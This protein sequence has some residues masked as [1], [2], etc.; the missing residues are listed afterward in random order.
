M[1]RSFVLNA[2]LILIP[3]AFLAQVPTQRSQFPQM[4]RVAL[5]DFVRGRTD[6][7]AS[8]PDSSLRE[9]LNRDERLIVIDRSMMQAALTGV[10]YAG[11]LN[12]TR[13]DARRLGSAIG[14]DFFIFGKTEALTRSEREHESHEE[15]YAGVLIVDGRTG[16]LAVFDFTSER[17]ATR[18]AAVNAVS[19]I[20]ASRVSSY[21][22]Q[23]LAH[24][25]SVQTHPRQIAD[26]IEDIPDEG[27]ARSYG[28][29][30]PVFLNRARPEYS[31][32][33]DMAD[34]TATVE[35]LA[36]LRA[37]GEVGEVEITRW[38]GFG[39]DESAERAI[40]QLKFKPAIR[41][42]KP[43][44]VRA[45]LRY[46]FRRLSE[47]ASPRAGVRGR[48]VGGQ[49]PLHNQESRVPALAG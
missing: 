3:F 24:R 35:A 41:D 42:G 30:P 15:A 2:F 40:R 4:L 43:V 21:V 31:A 48:A 49:R 1:F 44:S 17:A 22:D 14:C 16:E 5:I 34:V 26:A 20:L 38:A 18:E 7:G 23:M 10:G 29:T 28:F 27:S 47:P 9:A 33:A 19:K 32:Q 25:A 39:L 46:N 8:S 13:D 37:D 45:L 6:G 12:M 11:S 36:V